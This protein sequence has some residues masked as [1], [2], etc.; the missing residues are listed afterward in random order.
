MSFKAHFKFSQLVLSSLVVAGFMG[1]SYAANADQTPLFSMNSAARS[2]QQD[3]HDYIQATIQSDQGDVYDAA[4]TLDKLDRSRAPEVKDL[5]ALEK[6]L[7]FVRDMRFLSDDGHG[8]GM[9]RSTWLYPDDGC[10][11]R[12]DLARMHL[13]ELQSQEVS[14]LFVFGNLNVKTDNSTSG[15]VSWWYHVAPAVRID[16]DL[17]IIDPALSPKKSLKI[18]DWLSLQT[19]DLKSVTVSLCSSKSYGPYDPC[20][21]SSDNK[22]LA[23]SDQIDFLEPEW[24][25][26]IDLGREPSQVLGDNP[27]WAN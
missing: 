22:S 5:A 20:L 7:F 12:A 8:S 26:Q 13:S 21:S 6:D 17:Y 9:R 2:P 15:S 16:N 14:K 4:D 18:E 10:Y 23:N 25:R 1:V 19:T 11:A 3:F 24:Q 27:P